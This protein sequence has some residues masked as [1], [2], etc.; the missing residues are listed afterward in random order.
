VPDVFAELAADFARLKGFL[1]ASHVTASSP[2]F[3]VNTVR[4]ALWRLH[5]A[6]SQKLEGGRCRLTERH[7][8]YGHWSLYNLQL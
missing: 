8:P 7:G 6:W 3:D 4:S 5:A 2:S 1:F